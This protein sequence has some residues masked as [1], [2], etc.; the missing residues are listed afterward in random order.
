MTGE[1]QGLFRFLLQV[2]SKYCPSVT[3]RIAG[4]WVRDK[5][6]QGASNDI[7]IC[8]NMMG[9]PFAEYVNQELEVQGKEKHT[10]GLIKANPDLNKHLE[11]ASMRIEDTWVDF[12]N[13]RPAEYSLT[14]EQNIGTPYE[15]ATYRDLTINSMFYNI[16]EDVVEDWTQKGMVDLRGGVIDT[17]LPAM[18]TFCDDPLRV[19]RAIRFGVR[20]NFRL[21]P[22]VLEAAKDPEI[23]RKIGCEISRERIGKEIQGMMKGERAH[24]ALSYIYELDLIDVVFQFPKSKVFNPEDKIKCFQSALKF[25]K[26][27]SIEIPEDQCKMVLLCSFLLPFGRYTYNVKSKEFLVISHIFLEALKYTKKDSDIAI[28]YFSTYFKWAPIIKAYKETNTID[29]VEVG[30]LLREA[31]KLWIGSLI[32]GLL[33]EVEDVEEVISLYHHIQAL[34][35]SKNLIGVWDLKPFFDGKQIMEILSLSPSPAIGELLIKEIQWILQNP[36]HNQ[37]QCK[38]WLLSLPPT[39]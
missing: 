6:V 25:N 32:L 2:Q 26:I 20:F 17:P 33:V 39:H 30:M 15:D 12:V 37:D 35:T 16:N 14:K 19:L 22:S 29:R 8:L 24:M 13:L 9:Y 27:S 34:I 1:E 36:S 7:D 31:K 28:S 21:S 11:T 10:I 38:Q 18:R 5:L 4:G 3:L 23:K